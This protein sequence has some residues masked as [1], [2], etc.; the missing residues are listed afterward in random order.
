MNR[1]PHIAVFFVALLLVAADKKAKEPAPS[2]AKIQLW[3]KQLGDESFK[4]REEATQNLIKAGYAAFDAVTQATKSKD[5]EVKQRASRILKQIEKAAIAYFKK[6]GGLVRIRDGENSCFYLYLRDS[7]I[8]DAELVH[9]KGLTKLEIL[10]LRAKR[11]EEVDPIS[12]P[13]FPRG[14]KYPRLTNLFY[15]VG[16][17]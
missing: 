6:L 13:D 12:I 9:L 17:A 2:P 16:H 5:A 1:L 4:V 3:V 8:T 7:K 10:H 11:Q 14:S 15:F